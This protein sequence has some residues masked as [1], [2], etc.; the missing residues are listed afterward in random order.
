MSYASS[1][2]SVALVVVVVVVVAGRSLGVVQSG[3]M[4]SQGGKTVCPSKTWICPK[5]VKRITDAAVIA[6]YK[7]LVTVA[8]VSS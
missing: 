7:V 1:S 8:P 5:S 3:V 2:S 4:K 6:S